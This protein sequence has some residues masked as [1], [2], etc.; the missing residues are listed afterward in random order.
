MRTKRRVGISTPLGDALKFHRLSAREALSQVHAFELELLGSSNAIA[1]RALPGRSATVS[2][3][4]QTG[5]RYLGGI[6]S[7]FGLAR[8]DDR[9]TFYRM[10]RIAGDD[11]APS[12]RYPVP[13]PGVRGSQATSAGTGLRHQYSH[14]SGANTVIYNDS[15]CQWNA[16]YKAPYDL[17]GLIIF[18][19]PNSTF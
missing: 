17:F 10:R 13:P 8:Q 2:M 7:R 1:P 6:V 4:T 18:P 14:Q 9:Q 5:R 12:R 11:E 16:L 19:T 15:N 3:Q